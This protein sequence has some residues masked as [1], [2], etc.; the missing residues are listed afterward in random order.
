[1]KKIILITALFLFLGDCGLGPIPNP[2]FRIT[3]ESEVLVG[4]PIPHTYIPTPRAYARAS[5]SFNGQVI[6]QPPFT[7]TVG[8]FLQDSN[9]AGV[10]DV[11]NGKAAALWYFTAVANWDTCVGTSTFAEVF[12]GQNTTLVCRRIRL[13]FPIA[14]NTILSGA[15]PVE[16]QAQV[17]QVDTSHGMPIFQFEDYQG[18]LVGTATATQVNGTEAR[19]SSSALRN[20]PAGTYSVKV[21]NAPAPGDNIQEAQP[22]AYSALGVVDCTTQTDA[23]YSYTITGTSG[24]YTHQGYVTAEIVGNQ[25]HLTIDN[26][27]NIPGLSTMQP[28]APD[29]IGIEDDNGFI[30]RRGGARV[31]YP[32]GSYQPPPIGTGSMSTS[33]VSRNGSLYGRTEV[34]ADLNGRTPTK[35]SSAY[36]RQQG[37]AFAYINIRSCP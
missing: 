1:M 3:T 24:S 11:Q 22:F 12:P 32:G 35:Y 14:P 26:R 36:N 23:P 13:G 19:L 27:G 7:G 8:S 25:M 9:F 37:T 29:S 28:I 18:R 10:I 17:A 21:Y 5:G 16:L 4:F 20:Q 6:G 2:G 30:F 34:W 15:Y 31:I 33:Q